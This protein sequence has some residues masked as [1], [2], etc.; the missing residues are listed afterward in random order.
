MSV[1]KASNFGNPH[2]GIFAKA[3]EKMVIADISSSPKLLQALSLLGKEI[4]Q[5]TFGGMGMVGL[6]AAF[7][8][9]GIVVPPC[10]TNKEIEPFKKLGLNVAVAQSQFS[11]A[12]NNIA[13]N[14]FGGIANPML[15]KEELKKVQDCLGVEIVQMKIA[16][17]FTAGS[18]VLATNKGFI[19]HNRATEEQI[20][21]LESVLRVPGQN[22]T[23]NTGTTFVSL[24]AI[25]N[26]QGALFGELST[27]FEI[28]RASEA[29]GLI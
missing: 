28:G 1:A 2:I 5:C 18:L 3:S 23:L 16:N 25:A 29:L 15:P 17:Y 27:G 20:K 19:A 14:D 7:N 26:S 24:C 9:N 22:C 6:F 13:V 10:S 21:E 11:A 8:S 4:V 12:G